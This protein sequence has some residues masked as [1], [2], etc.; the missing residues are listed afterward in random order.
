MR[1]SLLALPMVLLFS[2]CF[3]T[4]SV[5]PVPFDTQRSSF[6]FPAGQTRLMLRSFTVENP[7]GKKTTNHELGWFRIEKDTLFGNMPAK[8]VDSRY[9]NPY[10]D[11]VFRRSQRDLY[12][13][14]DSQ[15]SVY[16]FKTRD[17][18]D[19]IGGFSV[20]L[21]KTADADTFIFSDRQVRL[22]YPLIENRPW[23][24]RP[25]ITDPLQPGEDLPKEFLGLDT[26]EFQGRN[27]VCGR[28]VLHGFGGTPILT[29]I[30]KLGLLKAEIDGSYIVTDSLDDSLGTGHSYESYSLL[31]L[32]IDSTAVPGYFG[33]YGNG[34]YPHGPDGL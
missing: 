23:S 34:P 20:G 22:K 33:R 19:Y 32:G 13:F 27:F 14:E 3:E 16:T 25:I 29:W 10:T 28:M 4:A 6:D 11:T 2:A 21:F 8:V 5:A 26:L 30:S 1:R 18:N 9:W 12:V 15:V 24:V 31:D 7:D 17:W